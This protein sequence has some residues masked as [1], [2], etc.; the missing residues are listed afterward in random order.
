VVARSFPK[1]SVLVEAFL[2][3]MTAAWEDAR[4]RHA[5]EKPYAFILYGVDGCIQFSAHV[6]THEGL[7][8]L[9]ERLFREGPYDTL[10]EV[11]QSF[12]F[13]VAD[14][15]NA[16]EEKYDNLPSVGALLDA[17][18]ETVDESAGYKAVG[19]AAILALKELDRR[20]L[21]GEGAA[22]QELTLAIITEAD[23][24][25]WL[26][27][28]V[29]QLNPRPVYD[30]VKK[31]YSVKGVHAGTDVLAFSP[32]GKFLYSAGSRHLSAD[33]YESIREIVALEC[34]QRRFRR[35][36]TF[37]FPSMGDSCDN[38]VVSP[39]GRY[40]FAARRQFVDRVA[41]TLLMRFDC[42]S[43]TPPKTCVIRADTSYVTLSHDG[44]QLARINREGEVGWLDA[45]LNALSTV[46]T[47]LQPCDVL[48]TQAGELLVGTQEGLYTLAP[49]GKERLV[50]K[51]RV[52]R[53]EAA[54]GVLAISQWLHDSPREGPAQEAS[55]IRLVSL[56][57]YEH[58]RM[59]E[60]P[61]HQF[62]KVAISM[63]AQFVAGEVKEIG[64][65]RSFIAVF[66]TASGQEIGRRKA[67][68]VGDLQFSPD[69]KVLAIATSGVTETE[70][71]DMWKVAS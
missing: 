1:Q 71:I 17:Y 24:Q 57:S 35:R 60:I 2:A 58:I 38:L 69:G 49:D 66:E 65:R 56:K 61:G 44:M 53:I 10:E 39:D 19:K 48:F 52:H 68:N 40:L 32:D 51:T 14:F 7:T 37:Q 8:A 55:G 29:K 27:Q 64:G 28:S 15:P 59:L 34:D 46:R 70:A 11:R 50:L 22:R 18:Q 63:D 13:C 30:R 54:Q 16:E 20:G 33:G 25:E 43:N 42:D 9:A 36:W 4:Q 21:F 26:L 41:Q 5:Q 31:L 67:Q 12:Q 23:P 45:E 6:L 47:A 62:L 3:D